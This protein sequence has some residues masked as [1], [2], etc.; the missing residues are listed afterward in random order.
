MHS[1]QH[2]LVGCSI[3]ILGLAPIHLSVSRAEVVQIQVHQHPPPPKLGAPRVSFP[4]IQYT[5]TGRLPPALHVGLSVTPSHKAGEPGGYG[6]GVRATEGVAHG[7]W[8]DWLWK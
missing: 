2:T 4:L 6:S 7:H 5:E 3:I 1:D 8:H